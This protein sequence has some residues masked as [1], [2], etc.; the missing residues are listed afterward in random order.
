MN[1]K[2]KEIKLCASLICANL[3]DIEKDIK[4]LEEEDFDYLHFDVMDGNFVPRIGL[5][6]DIL[7]KITSKFTIP[8]EVHLMVKNPYEYIEKIIEAGGS[9]IIIHPEGEYN[10]ESIISKIS[11]HKNIKV[12]LALKPDSSL[13]I[14][15]PYLDRIELLMLMTYPPGTLGEKPIKNFSRRIYKLNQILS[16]NNKE[17][18]YISV[19]GGVNTCNINSYINNGANMFVLGSNGLFI[20]DVELKNQI[21]LI[22][23]LIDSV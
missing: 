14:I 22:K 11:K 20:E 5:S 8:V 9:I 10:V 23:K 21:S 16:R 18:I 19:D 4:I 13:N 1:L 7:K 15:I 2:K 3:L 17:N 6:L 12:G